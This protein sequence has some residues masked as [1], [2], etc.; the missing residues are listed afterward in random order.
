MAQASQHLSDPKLS[1]KLIIGELL[2]NMELGRFEMSYTVL[3]PCVFTVY[4]HPEDHAALKGVFG[5]IIED[6]RRSFRARVSQLNANP[7][8]FGIRR[9]GQASK[10]HKIACAD[11][12]IEFFP[13]AEVPAGDVE[14]HS[15]L[16]E[17]PE[18]GYR[19]TKTTLLEREPSA[20]PQRLTLLRQPESRT[21]DS[22][23]AE[24]HYEDDSGPQVY[25]MTQNV[26]RIGRGGDDQPA[27]LVLHASDEVSRGHLQ[28]RR[29][30]AT[31]AFFITDTSTNGTWLN[32]KRLR[33]ST[34]EALP[35][36]AEIGIGEV[37]K[38][39]FKVR[40]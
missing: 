37:L 8:A 28:L 24:I 20:S 36:K 21:T 9:L 15:Q 31:G 16:S 29:D 19:G 6:A 17:T 30:G 39:A 10:E 22:V 5:H 12:L 33:K 25:L 4:L 38:L 18:P 27:D 32:G 26:V 1:G 35:D 40:Q 2:R 3:L 11:W 34:E 13:D 14:I 7:T 23:Y